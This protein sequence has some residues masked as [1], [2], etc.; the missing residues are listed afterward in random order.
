MEIKNIDKSNMRKTILDFP[1][2]FKVGINA[3]KK[4]HFKEWSFLTPPENIIVCGMGGSAIAG[5][6]LATLKPFDVFYYKSYRLPLQAGN[7]SLI[8]CIS[9]SGNTEETLS[10]FET[11][12][13]KGLPVI[14]ITTGGKLAELSKKYKVPC[15]IL[16]PPYFPPRLAIGEMFAALLQVLNNHH[17]SNGLT[18]KDI[19][20][21]ENSL[22]IKALEIE[23]KKIAKKIFGKIPIIYTSRR[24]RVARMIWKN[25]LN[26]TAKILAI[27]NYFPELN[28][29][30]I[31]GLWRVNEAQ[32]SNDKLYVLIL[33]DKESSH[34]RILKQMEI[35]KN[36]LTKEGIEAEFIDIKGKN[37]LEKLFSIA[38]LGFWVSFWLAME[39]KIDPTPVDPI[40]ELKKKLKEK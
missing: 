1:K 17:L 12:V 27:A 30:E 15:V 21:I 33:R 10:S 14:S 32:I 18:I 36:F 35:T 5:E 31:V 23:G 6:M 38:I 40:N 4:V 13:G 39:Y 19:L 25:S 2:Q 3:A 26:E 24:F 20:K 28:H 29:N 37:F 9:Y 7:E 11:A 22:N 34:P 16:P 8:I